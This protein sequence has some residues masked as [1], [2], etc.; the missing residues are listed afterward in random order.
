[1]ADGGRR[2]ATRWALL[3]RHP[4]MPSFVLLLAVWGLVSE[5]GWVGST[6]VAT[7]AEV[8]DAFVAATRPGA[9]DG[10]NVWLHANGTLGR[11]A[12]G[13]AIALG[14]GLLVGLGAGARRLVYAGSEPLVELARSVPPIMVFPVLLVAFDYSDGAYVGTI[15]FGCVPVMV[16]TV[17]RGVQALSRPK[18]EVLRVHR[19]R[20]SVRALALVMELL[21]SVVLGAR[22]TLSISLVIAVVTEMVFSPRSGIALGALAKE[23][24][25][26][27]DTPVFYAAL[28]VIAS[29]GYLA[30]VGLRWI[31]ERLLGKG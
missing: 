1:M 3:R 9:P 5:L 13:W 10:R 16:I 31:E 11:A 4:W 14:L 24:E 21:P 20:S 15:V 6:L 2:G 12:T 19:V 25:V 18:L 30:N 29:V 26:A 8:A 22:L 7:P 23:A 17:A 27:F 28:V